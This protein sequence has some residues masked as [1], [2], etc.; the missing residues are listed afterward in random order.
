MA[1]AN[2]F[3]RTK[4][5]Y[6]RPRVTFGI[7]TLSR[8]EHVQF[9]ITSCLAQTIPCHVI[10]A[11]Q[12]QSRETAAIM[13]RY[14]DHPH[15]EHILSDATCL[16]DNWEVAA[17]ACDTEFFCWVQDD[18]EI[19][20][21]WAD[22]IVK[23]FDSFPQALHVQA[24][25][26]VTPDR[27]HSLKWAFNGP[28]L[29]VNMKSLTPE[30]WHGEYCVAPMYIMSWALSPGIAFRCGREFNEALEAMPT[31]A[32]LFTER[33]I[34]AEMG[35]R[36]DLV[37]D[38]VTAGYWHHHGKNLSYEQNA[39]GSIAHQYDVLVERL[40]QV[41]DRTPQWALGMTAWCT[42]RAAHEVMAWLKETTQKGSK[43]PIAMSRHSKEIQAAMA[44]S[45]E[46]RVQG[47]VGPLVEDEVLV[48]E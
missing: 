22:R 11:D 1:T 20:P 40:D 26:Y 44:Q 35:S 15:V 8:P 23:G 46:G 21:I 37:T 24:F 39:D 13:E 9:A 2:G 31:D 30:C 32:D 41:L 33:L 12:G 3:H 7:P 43:H 25:C 42:M 18:D 48:F 6:G 38:P 36:G 4:A 27:I 28:A 45:L 47:V 19:S 16:Q 14:R 10:V 5:A 29:G 34:V 17:R